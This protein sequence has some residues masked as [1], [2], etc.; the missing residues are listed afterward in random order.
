MG[1]RGIAPTL[2]EAFEQAALAMT[3]AKIEPALIQPAE[4]VEISCEAPAPD[5]LL[6]SRRPRGQASGGERRVCDR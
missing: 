6:A 4:E 1:V 2:A 3:A 5:L